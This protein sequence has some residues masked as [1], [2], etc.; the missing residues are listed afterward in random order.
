MKINLYEELVKTLSNNNKT[1]DDIL[2]VM[3]LDRKAGQ[4]YY[5]PDRFLKRAKT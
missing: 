3:L 2:Y 4:K 1:V 5:K